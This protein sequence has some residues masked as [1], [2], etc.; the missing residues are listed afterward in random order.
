MPWASGRT[1]GQRLWPRP[2]AQARSQS[3]AEIEEM[4]LPH[5]GLGPSP[6][7]L[8]GPSVDVAMS[9]PGA[10]DVSE[11]LQ[12]SDNARGGGG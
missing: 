10:I 5:Q 3:G 12:N 8:T 9:P 4:R 2:R 1:L 11:V 7:K 6:L